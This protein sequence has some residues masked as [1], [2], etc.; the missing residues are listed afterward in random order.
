MYMYVY[1]YVYVYVYMYVYMY[2][3]SS[4]PKISAVKNI[5]RTNVNLHNI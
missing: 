2:M 5:F 3:Y 1:V 4:V